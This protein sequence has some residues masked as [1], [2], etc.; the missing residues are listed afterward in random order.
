MRGHVQGLTGY[1]ETLM[2]YNHYQTTIGA[3]ILRTNWQ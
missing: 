1:G 2:D 3:G